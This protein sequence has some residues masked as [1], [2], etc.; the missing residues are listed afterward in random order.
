MRSYRGKH[1][2]VVV[3]P[4]LLLIAVQFATVFAPVTVAP[5][6]TTTTALLDEGEKNI[7]LCHSRRATTTTTTR[8]E[9]TPAALVP[10]SA[11]PW[12]GSVDFPPV[13]R[14]MISTHDPVAEDIYIS[15]SVHAA[16]TPW[17]PYVWDLF[18]RVLHNAPADAAVVDVGANIGYFSLMAAS[19][20]RRVIA[21]E[22]MQRNVNRFLASI[23][24]NP[25]FAQRITVYQ[26]VVAHEAGRSVAL[27]ATHES[28]SG[29][30]QV[31]EDGTERAT[32]V[33][34]DDVPLPPTVALLKLDVEGMEL[35]A[36]D[37][38]RRLLSSGRVQHIVLE[39]S[40]ATRA[41]A[42]C[43]ARKG[44]RMLMALGYAL[45]DVVPHAPLLSPDNDDDPLPPNL[46]LT[47]YTSASSVYMS[48]GRT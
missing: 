17:D 14:F 38:A 41:N 40:E 48:S 44:L 45:S 31:H 30:G 39:W 34:L 7:G 16:Q 20:G 43:P 13:P 46:L 12:W 29:N 22:P 19:L 2:L 3:V 26:N 6:S 23:A 21:F 4:F 42:D 28:N 47:W 32:T 9:A 10:S 1:F 8:V 15:G 37:G 36:L 24:R 25:D 11:P 35:S 27:R 5:A 18:L 33:R